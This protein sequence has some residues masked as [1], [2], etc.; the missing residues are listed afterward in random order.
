MD[1]LLQLFHLLQRV[2]TIP[3]L[4]RF[5]LYLIGFFTFVQGCRV[6]NFLSVH[7]P[8]G[9]GSPATGLVSVWPAGSASQGHQSL[10]ICQIASTWSSSV[11]AT[12]CPYLSPRL[13]TT[14]T[15]WV[16][17]VETPFPTAL[18]ARRRLKS[19]VKVQVS[20][21][22]DVSTS[23]NY[24]CSQPSRGPGFSLRPSL[25]SWDGGRRG[26]TFRLMHGSYE[27][28]RRCHVGSPGWSDSYGRTA[29]GFCSL[30]R[31]SAWCSFGFGG[32]RSHCRRSWR[33]CRG[34]TVCARGS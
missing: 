10:V 13:P 8:K 28:T 9:L 19:I 24:E 17:S 31:L 4:V 16:T 34:G 18:Q 33:N 3:W 2:F 7:E 14:G 11:K 12:R 21:C 32:S 25:A 29:G 23:C 30:H 22:R 27:K 5:L 15:S 26:W 20:H 6:E 1:Q